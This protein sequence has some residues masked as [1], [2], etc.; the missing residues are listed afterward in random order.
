MQHMDPHLPD[1]AFCKFL[2]DF[3]RSTQNVAPAGSNLDGYFPTLGLLE[4]D[5]ITIAIIGP[6]TDRMI[7]SHDM[8]LQMTRDF[9]AQRFKNTGRWPQAVGTSY[10]DDTGITIWV[11]TSDGRAALAMLVYSGGTIRVKKHNF[12][13][14]SRGSQ[15][16]ARNPAAWFFASG[17]LASFLP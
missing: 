17:P 9:G 3:V 15:G 7:E 14:A 12:G 10:R 11:C 16:I 1:A 8:L 5:A 6:E 4:A 2:D 13:L